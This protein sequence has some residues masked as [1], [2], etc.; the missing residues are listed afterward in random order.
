M[1]RR[2][3]VDKD[4][5]TDYT[6]ITYPFENTIHSVLMKEYLRLTSLKSQILGIRTKVK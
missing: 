1:Q 4:L 6:S 5:V 2:E 3:G